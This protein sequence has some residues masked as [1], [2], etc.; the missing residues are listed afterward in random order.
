M[1]ENYAK[2]DISDSIGFPVFPIHN[3]SRKL[4]QSPGCLQEGLARQYSP[5]AGNQLQPSIDLASQYTITKSDL[6][7]T[8]I[9]KISS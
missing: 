9:A 2:P 6:E 7:I 5:V 1:N 3:R 4:T 8:S